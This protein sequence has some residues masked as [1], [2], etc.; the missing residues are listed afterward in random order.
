M[1]TFAEQ[2][3][4]LRVRLFDLHAEA[5]HLATSI[6]AEIAERDAELDGARGELNDRPQPNE[7]HQCGEDAPAS[8]LALTVP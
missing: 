8:P 4:A 5:L 3:E 6:E 2:I 1:A 7:T